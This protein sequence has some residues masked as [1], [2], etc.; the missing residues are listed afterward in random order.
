M[1][2]G[3]TRLRRPRTAQPPPSLR[4]RPRHARTCSIAV[5]L[6]SA[7]RLMAHN[8]HPGLDPGSIPDRS[9]Q[10]Q[11]VEGR[12]NTSGID[13]RLMGRLRPISSP[14]PPSRGPSL[15]PDA[16]AAGGE[17]AQPPKLQRGP[18]LGPG[19]GAGATVGVALPSVPVNNRW[20]NSRYCR[21]NRGWTPDQVRGDEEGRPGMTERRSTGSDTTGIP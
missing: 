9:R 5:R 13:F 17:Q 8:R 19:S 15:A 10:P 12:P 3:I 11:P 2:L 20:Y 18:K 4:L 14:R 16:A 1:T 6:A 21:E 7:L